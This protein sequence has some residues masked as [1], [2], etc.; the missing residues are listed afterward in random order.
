MTVEKLATSTWNKVSEV[1]HGNSF[2]LFQKLALV[3]IYQS[4]EI[5]LEKLHQVLIGASKPEFQ[6]FEHQ[7]P[8]LVVIKQ[9]CYS[10]ISL[11]YDPFITL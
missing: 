1:L 4:F 6:K 7:D 10:I 5:F 11:S 3:L 8:S 9:F 2:S